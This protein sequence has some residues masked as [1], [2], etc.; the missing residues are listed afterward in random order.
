MSYKPNGYR[1]TSVMPE[2]P[3]SDRA[4]ILNMIKVIEAGKKCKRVGIRVTADTYEAL[5]RIADKEKVSVS[6]VIRVAIYEL[7]KHYQ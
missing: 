3:G 5:K 2:H 4:L 7:T 1:T 6:D